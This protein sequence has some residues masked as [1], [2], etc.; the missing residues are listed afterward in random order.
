MRNSPRDTS[1]SQNLNGAIVKGISWNLVETAVSYL[2]HFVIGIILARLLM[3]ADYGVVGVVA[4]FVTISDACVKAGFGQAYIRKAD[5]DDT[6]ANTVFYINL[7]ISLLLYVALYFAAPAI[8]RYFH[9]PQLVQIVRVLCL[10]IVINA[11]TVI[12][13]AILRKHLAFKKKAIASIVSGLV[14]GI[15]GVVCAYR[16]WGVWSLVVQQLLSKGLYCVQ[17]HLFSPWHPSLRFSG[18]RAQSMFAYGGWLLLAE[19]LTTVMNNFYRFAIGRRYPSEQLG[20][21]DRARQFQAIIADTFT[22]VLGMVAFPSLAKVQHTPQQMRE[23]THNYVRYSTWVIYPLLGC[24]MVLAEPVVRVLITDKWLPCVPYLQLFCLVGFAVPAQFFLSP[25]L[26][27]ADMTRLNFISTV[28]L[29]LLRVANFLVTFRY[30]IR[31]LLVGE[32]CVLLLNTA[33]VS[34]VAKPR[35][36]HNYLSV[37]WEARLTILSAAAVLAVGFALRHWLLDTGDWAQILLVGMAMLL[38]YALL[39]LLLQR[40]L[41]RKILKLIARK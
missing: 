37:L 1:A 25:L 11:L 15:V 8:A 24:L 4:I 13:L 18:R 41:Y 17:L 16:G 27:A 20:L 21:Y 5:A 7:G 32:F 3:P 6:D 14:S 23:V 9:E 19:V 30:G 26:Q 2:I 28:L 10:V 33:I 29:T 35:L 31:Y 39:T 12:Q 34:L 36:G 22:G 38:L 40:D